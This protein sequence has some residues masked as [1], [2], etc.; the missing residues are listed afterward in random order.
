[1]SNSFKPGQG[2]RRKTEQRS[3][4]S[5]GGK[6]MLG[7][8]MAY[9]CRSFYGARECVAIRGL[10]DR[11]SILSKYQINYWVHRCDR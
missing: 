1:M 8:T 3:T 2:P 11:R 9:T 7:M 10:P 6:V 5:E 4:A